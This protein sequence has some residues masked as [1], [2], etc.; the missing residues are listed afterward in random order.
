[1]CK[2]AHTVNSQNVEFGKPV[3]KLSTS[4]NMGLAFRSMRH[5]GIGNFA[6]TQISEADLLW[7]QIYE[8]LSDL[9]AV[10]FSACHLICSNCCQVTCDTV[11]RIS[12]MWW[13]FSV[14]SPGALFPTTPA[15]SLLMFS[16]PVY[17]VALYV[18]TSSFFRHRGFLLISFLWFKFLMS[19]P[20]CSHCTS[21]IPSLRKLCS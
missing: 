19:I 7:E 8:L 6:E 21:S 5:E 14:S 4:W 12:G 2:H 3:E 13:Y 1:M 17:C 16:T 10:L 20:A 11:V 9:L 18:V 15:F